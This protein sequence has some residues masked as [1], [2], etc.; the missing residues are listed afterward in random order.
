M[1]KKLLATV[2][3]LLAF[4]TFGAC[5]VSKDKTETSEEDNKPR[6]ELITDVTYYGCPNSKRVKKLNLLKK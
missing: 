2:L 6:E 1:K 4:V 3:V 5:K